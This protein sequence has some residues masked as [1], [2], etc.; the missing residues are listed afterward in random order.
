MN[1]KIIYIL[2]F[3][4]IF[5]PQIAIADGQ[6]IEANSSLL[7]STTSWT[8]QRGSV[9]NFTFT[10]SP[11]QPDTYVVTGTYVN[12]A[13]GY[14]CKGTPYPLT[15]FYYAPTNVI[16]FSVA[17]SNATEDCR[18]ITGWTGYLDYSVNPP[19]LSTDWNLAF[20][21]SAG[22]QIQQ[23][24]DTFTKSATRVSDNLQNASN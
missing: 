13:A 9:A 7:T 12:N 15:G 16:S 24:K 20:S 14:N 5:V 11:T 6:N 23:G 17:W 4:I 1:R 19:Q 2:S 18:S 3:F 10:Q 22:Q 8:N 21:G